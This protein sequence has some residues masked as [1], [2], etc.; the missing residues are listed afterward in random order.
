MVITDPDQLRD[1]KVYFLPWEHAA[2]LQMIDEFGLLQ[3]SLAADK[4]RAQDA[5]TEQLGDDGGLWAVKDESERLHGRATPY[6]QAR[7][8]AVV[9]DYPDS[10]LAVATIGS[11]VRV[12]A[13]PGKSYE[14]DIVGGRN[15]KGLTLATRHPAVDTSTYTS[16]LGAA[17]IGHKVGD[18]V[19]YT[20]KGSKD[21]AFTVT[22]LAID[23]EAQRR[24]AEAV[25]QAS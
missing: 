4:S 6:L 22:I 1:D 15:T 17:L 19:P 25:N 21:R 9:L 5:T 16:P 10:G 3:V 23:Q 8:R 13:S 24:E 20:I 2:L 14:V 18:K 11:R 7:S 12:E